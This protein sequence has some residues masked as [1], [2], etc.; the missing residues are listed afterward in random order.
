[1][2]SEHFIFVIELRNICDL[3]GAK[4]R[5]KMGK[6]LLKIKTPISSLA[7]TFHSISFLFDI[8]NSKGSKLLVVILGAIEKF[9]FL[10][11]KPPYYNFRIKFFL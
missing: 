1:M 6:N 9:E 2:K 10:N 8:R 5:W 7:E 4:T 3:K 11:Q